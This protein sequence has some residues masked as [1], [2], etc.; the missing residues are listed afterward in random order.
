MNKNIL[1]PLI[2]VIGGIIILIILNKPQKTT[3]NS[4][5]TGQ[6]DN[7]VSLKINDQEAPDGYRTIT[8]IDGV[9]FY[10]IQDAADTAT[11]VSQISDNVDFDRD[12]YYS[13][14]DGS[15]QY[16]L[17]NI[18]GLVVAAQKGTNFHFETNGITENALKSS[19]V[20][21]IWFDK[22]GKKI[23][24]DEKDG[25]YTLQ[26]NGGVVITNEL[27]G[28]FAGK[29]KVI[30]DGTE[31]WS[32][33]AGVE[34]GSY[35]EISKDDKAIINNIVGSIHF[36]E[37]KE[38]PKDI[39]AVSLGIQ[40]SD[41]TASQQITSDDTQR[42]PEKNA[43]SDEH[44]IAANHLNPTKQETKETDSQRETLSPTTSN[45]EKYNE[46]MIPG[47]DFIRI[48]SSKADINHERGA[49]LNLTNQREIERSADNAYTSDAYSMLN[50]GD[51]GI[52]NVYDICTRSDETPIIN[53]SQLLTGKEAEKVIRNYCATSNAPYGYFGPPN[54]CQWHV[55]KYSLNYKKCTGTPYIDIRLRGLDGEALLQ[56]GIKYTSRT[57]DIFAFTMENSDGWIDNFYCYYAVPNGCSEYA[58]EIG[59]PVMNTSQLGTAFYQI[60]S[61]ISK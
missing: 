40:E 42:L 31:E 8:A 56:R 12:N 43:N 16:L 46:T 30:S 21:G 3:E 17:F 51:S 36:A 1:F 10:V 11:A 5:I 24:S 26:A 60:N 2:G 4:I 25:A 39:Y 41:S 54:G 53:I 61:V 37:H 29:L 9:S 15:S 23:E 55:I 44:T 47:T 58:L 13:Y 32:I 50:I 18:S 6:K 28:N 52:F 59:G 57:H 45:S 27:Y 7:I 33:F 19:S 48:S 49:S 38:P 22:S 20:T 14:K 35:K 34:A